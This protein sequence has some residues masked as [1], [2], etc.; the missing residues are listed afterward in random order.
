MPEQQ[1]QQ[2]LEHEGEEQ[3]Q[4]DNTG[5]KGTIIGGRQQGHFATFKKIN[6]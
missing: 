1:Q 6:F 5:S 3:Q 2:Q 4:Q